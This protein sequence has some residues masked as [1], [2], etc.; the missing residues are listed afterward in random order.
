MINY[1]L[2]YPGHKIWKIHIQSQVLSEETNITKEGGNI[3]SFE[4]ED[5]YW[6]VSALNEENASRQFEERARRLHEK[7]NPTA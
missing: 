2:K 4:K 3:V 6:Y 7:L 5:G 1:L